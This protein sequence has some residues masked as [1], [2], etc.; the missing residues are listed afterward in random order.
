[1]IVTA[2]GEV[3]GEGQERKKKKEERRRNKEEEERRI[4]KKKKN[5]KK[6]KKKKGIRKTCSTVCLS[7]SSRT[8]NAC[9]CCHEQWA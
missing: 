3:L 7:A 8:R 2:G 5:K 4:N 9:G 6:K 1:V